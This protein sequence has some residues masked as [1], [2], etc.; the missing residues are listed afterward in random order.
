[1]EE[2]APSVAVGRAHR[3]REATPKPKALSVLPEHTST[4]QHSFFRYF[5]TSPEII[6]LA[7]MMYV[8]FP[9]SLRNVKD[10]LHAHSTE[11]GQSFH[12]IVGSHS[13]RWWAA[14]LTDGFL[15]RATPQLLDRS[16]AD[17]SYC[18]RLLVGFDTLEVNCGG[19]LCKLAQVLTVRI[20]DNAGRIAVVTGP[21]GRR[22]WPQHVKAAI[23]L[24]TFGDGVSVADI[25]RTHSVWVPQL[26]ARRWAARD[27]W[28]PMPTD[29]AFGLVPVIRA[30]GGANGGG[31][32]AP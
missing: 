8:R 28:L 17:S 3:I 22:R 4:I 14:G 12:A 10:V 30:G 20:N 31:G 16:T 9:L 26:H 6:R 19:R 27:G 2:N 13:T 29:D 7:V 15:D 18:L 24:E 23:V 1:M 21:S 25:A 32:A 11:D 5:K